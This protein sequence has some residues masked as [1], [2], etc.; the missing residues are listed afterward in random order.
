M[1]K[2]VAIIGAGAY[3]SYAASVIYDVHPEW[4]VHI[5]EV[6][7]KKIKTQDEIGFTSKITN[8][9]YDALTKGRYFG[10]G[11]ATAKWGGQILTFSKNDFI[12]PNR[13][14]SGII[15]LNEK[16]RNN[17][18]KKIGIVNNAPEVILD[19]GMYAKVGVWLDYFHRNLFYL[20]GV[21]KYK[22]VTLHPYCRVTKILYKGKKVEGFQY[23]ENGE[24]KIA[25]N[26]DFFFLSAGAFESTRI[27]MVSGLQSLTKVEF[28]D[29]IA[30]KIFKI[31]GTTKIGKVDMQFKTKKFSFITTR[32]IGEKD[33]VSYF[34]YPSFNSEF[35]LFQNLKKLLFN[36]HFSLGLVGT[37]VKDLPNVVRFVW[38]YFIKHKLYVHKNEWYLVLHMEN[39]RG[40]GNVFLADELDKFRQPGLAISFSISEKSEAI[41]NSVTKMFDKMLTDD[42]IEHYLI[43]EAVHTE[44]FEDE[45]HPFG[46]YS[47]FDS[48]EDYFNQFD[49]MLVV[50]SGVL[51]RAGGINS[52][53]AVFPLLE[54]FIRHYM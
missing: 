40:H 8:N 44:K 53:S 10:F 20:F 34:G 43:D 22:N 24:Y 46:L 47:D 42:K 17:I 1:K 2:N 48:V 9:R 19:N 54:E 29:H 37:I 21:D 49:N 30:K 14:L 27:M 39:P 13:Y 7:D 11:G 4:N 38:N 33:G 16:Y 45:Y 35:P 41:F 36:H 23:I 52:T 51:P 25:S 15:E 31:K 26:Y 5:F 32:I 28:S 6:G 18:F 3:A 12:D 50:H